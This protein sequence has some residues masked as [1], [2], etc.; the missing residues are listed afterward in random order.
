MGFGRAIVIG[1][2]PIIQRHKGFPVIALEVAVM[3][4][5][6]ITAGT[7][8]PEVS[9]DN[10]L[11]EPGMPLGWRKRVVLGVH[12][13]VDRMRG[14][15]PVNQH[16]TEDDQVLNRMHGHPGPGTDIDVF[17][18]EV[19]RPLEERRPVHETMDPV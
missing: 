7:A 17:V 18:M 11:L 12:Q 2:E 4:V 14:H 1:P 13:H 5:M 8:N 9:L 15:N 10:Q 3:Q 19:V 16:T 6:E